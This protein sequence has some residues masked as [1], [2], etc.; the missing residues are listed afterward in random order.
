VTSAPVTTTRIAGLEGLRGVA[1]LLIVLY[2]ARVSWLHGDVTAVDV[3]FPL[4]GFVI[5]RNLLRERARTDTIDLTRF[6][7]RR[8][9]RLLPASAVAILLTL[10]VAHLR[11]LPVTFPQTLSA[12]FG[13]KNW[14]IIA[15]GPLLDVFVIWWSLAIEEQYYLVYPL[16]V[17]LVLRSSGV[18][19]LAIALG[20]TTLLSCLAAFVHY[21]LD[22]H[23]VAYYSTHTRLWELL[24]GCLLA[25]HDRLPRWLR[26]PTWL[27]SV[28]V[29]VSLTSLLAETSV[30]IVEPLR[31]VVVVIG[32]VMVID[33]VVSERAGVTGALLGSWPLRR[34][35][36][37][38]YEMYLVHTAVLVADVQISDTRFVQVIGIVGLTMVAATLVHVLVTPLRERP[39]PLGAVP[40]LAADR[41]LG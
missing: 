26:W 40:S 38:S 22:Q 13:F 12:L 8:V 20:A 9:R 6:W 33:A 28:I 11:E 16:V 10:L 32:T 31:I 29:V 25:L 7:T 19:A 24:I 18:R 1:A 39:E 34:L 14:Q 30:W 3:F 4:S 15:G 5:T 21:G 27:P 35:G 36:S 37:I 17:G 23:T 2:H 41:N